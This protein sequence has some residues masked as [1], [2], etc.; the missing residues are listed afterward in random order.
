MIEGH[1]RWPRNSWLSSNTEEKV[2]RSG[3]EDGLASRDTETQPKCAGTVRRAKAQLELKLVWNMQKGFF[4]F[5]GRKRRVKEKGLQQQQGFTTVQAIWWQR[6]LFILWGWC[7]QYLFLPVLTDLVCLH[8]CQVPGSSSRVCVC[9]V[10]AT[11]E[12]G[13]VNKN[14]SQLDIPKSMEQDTWRH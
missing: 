14:L 8:A 9:K 12:E 13:Q 3:S 10:L 4:K 6:M 7:T 11:I 2:H 5:T 1:H